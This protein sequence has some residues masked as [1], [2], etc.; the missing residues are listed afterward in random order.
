MEKDRIDDFLRVGEKVLWKGEAAEFATF[1]KT[2]KSAFLRRTVLSM[3]VAVLLA[4]LYFVF[5]KSTGRV[6]DLRLVGI[7]LLCGAI[8]PVTVTTDAG[9]IRRFRYAATDQRL[10]VYESTLRQMDYRRIK[11]AKFITDK[12]G[13]TTLVCGSR[14]VQ[15]S[16]SKWRSLTVYGDVNEQSGMDPCKCFVMY[17]VDDPEGLRRVLREKLLR[18]DL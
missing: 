6:P 18:C 12:D 10:M 15:S 8:S 9:Q 2:Y 17:A 7:C 14:G 16:P 13:L 3:G 4:V 11:E 1:N 5:A